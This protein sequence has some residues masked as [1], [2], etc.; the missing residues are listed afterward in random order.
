M[1]R[2]KN[3]AQFK[4]TADGSLLTILAQINKIRGHTKLEVITE[5]LIGGLLKWWGLTRQRRLFCFQQMEN[6]CPLRT[7]S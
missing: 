5:E 2:Q 6:S 1:F 7:S 4:T 3:I